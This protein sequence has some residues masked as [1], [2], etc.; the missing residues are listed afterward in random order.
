MFP[1]ETSPASLGSA[2]A[3]QRRLRRG[4]TRSGPDG[5]SGDSY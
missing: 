5:G 1:S 4:W 2:P 3:Y